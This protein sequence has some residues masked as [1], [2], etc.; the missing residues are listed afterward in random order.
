MTAASDTAWR[1][2]FGIS[3]KRSRGFFASKDELDPRDAPVPHAHVVRRAFDLLKLDGVLC[4]QAAPLVYFKIVRRIQPADV[5]DL[6][7]RFWN[8]G[9]APILALI[10]PHEVQVYSGLSRPKG[11]TDTSAHVPGLVASIDRA[12]AALR[13]FLPAVE[14]GEFFR[15]HARSFNP[16]DRV[17]RALLDKLQATR[18]KLGDVAT[19]RASVEILDAL[20]CRLVF[21]C[22]LFDREVIGASYLRDLDL[23]KLPHLRDVLA[24]KPR[25]DAKSA[26]Y[27]LFRQ[28]AKDFNGD[29]FSDDLDAEA[30][31]VSVA[32][33]D[34]VEAFFRATDVKSG[35]QAFWPYDFGV[36]PIETISAIYERFLK[37]SDKKT[38]AFY[39]PRFLA[40]LVLDV[41]LSDRPSL[42]GQRFLDP[43]C[44]SGIFLVGLF[45]RMAEEW[46]RA[47]PA[48]RNDRRARE[49]M[50]ILRSSIFGVDVN[51]TACRIT[52]F[53]LYL[54]Y[55]DQL[56]PRDIHELQKKGGAL[57]RLVSRLDQGNASPS[58]G[59][60][61]CGDF[62]Q[63][64]APYPSDV[65]LVV[66]NPP[67][68]SVAVKG[69]AAA[70]WCERRQRPIP[71]KQIATAFM[72]KAAEQ[73]SDDGRI[74]L[75]L[76]HGVL[77]NHSPLAL[78]FQKAFIGEHALDC[79]L[80]L[81]DYQSFLFSKARHPALVLS[82]R[83]QKPDRNHTTEY[84]VPKAD[85]KVTKAEVI[86]VSEHD[87]STLTI[88]SILSDLDG[89]D[90]PQ[91]WKRM[92]WA[93]PRD[94]R[95]LDRLAALPRLRDR[96]RQARD[97]GTAGPWLI[98]EGFQPLGMN[99]DPDRA[100]VLELPSNLFIEA[101]SPL[102]QLFLL[103]DDCDRRRSKR[104]TVRGRSNKIVDPFRGP[105]VLV[106]QGFGRIAFA[107][108]DVSFQHALRGICGPT[109][110]RK[111]LLFLAAYLRSSL[112]QY[113]LFHTSSNWG[114]SRKK[115][116]V[117]ELLRLPFPMPDTLD[118]AA[119]AKQIVEEVSRRVQAAA[120][121]AQKA[122]ADRDAL[123][124]DAQSEIEELIYEYFDVLPSERIL[125]EDT[126]RLTIPSFRPG[127]R[128]P[129]VPA[130]DPSTTN[131][132]TRYTDR[133][134]ATLNG[135]ANRGDARVVGSATASECVGIGLV[136]LEK[137]SRQTSK[138]PS[139]ANGDLLAAL[140][141]LRDAAS[142]KGN[143]YELARGVKVFDGS[144]L[145]VVKPIGR[146]YWTESA[147]LNDAD[148]IAGSILMHPPGETA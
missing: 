4:D 68:G 20:L 40:E 124:A 44:G 136:V 145:Y 32:H 21:T 29:L 148:E 39:T 51:P 89:E 114:V 31:L 146:R 128:R 85:W 2:E 122:L 139:S 144:R 116:H 82:Y 86:T 99:D 97:R 112:A 49:L 15:R 6:H 54:A 147:A 16:T 108:F 7:H 57:P 90:A 123:V 106:A 55:L 60:I 41:A 88:R 26:L 117:E 27:S 142:L 92:S 61:W 102:L 121:K 126:V 98:A 115:V 11:Q 13:E 109:P 79:V 8:H 83:K 103:P 131:D 34:V 71:D 24:L 28:L 12:S 25:S 9:G 120:R 36:I 104:V 5:S 96:V 75:V 30:A 69:S 66:G 125:V 77:F 143:T 23:P 93:S 67:W 141:R 95:L 64:G 78:S 135:W 70:E 73:A 72:W 56:T 59:G 119:R 63:K 110:D 1:A 80:N 37:P 19:R 91:I 58:D 129:S 140:D 53:S 137:V 132:R 84:W 118:D 100:A 17:D 18:E 33:L 52:A 47:N 43:A 10:A 105:H 101:S 111:L 22:Y 127:P 134:C 74:C 42:L 46:R 113:Y 130:I 38:G 81:T 133:L 87:R 62:F 50:E 3:E 107:E 45:N 76:P 65:D 94:R 48:A 138:S 14:S 35:Q